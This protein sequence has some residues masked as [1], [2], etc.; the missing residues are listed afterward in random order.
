[1]A[2]KPSH[3][4]LAAAH[5]I[6]YVR[7]EILGINQSEMAEACKVVQSM[8]SF[9]EKGTRE[10]PYIFLKRLYIVYRI[11]PI[12]IMNGVKPIIEGRVSHGLEE[13]VNEIRAELE[14]VKAHLQL[15]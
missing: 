10:I 12:Y 15:N 14:I 2:P 1:M 11:S 8:V 4:D 6:K 9:I 5:R 3:I 13:D 7:E